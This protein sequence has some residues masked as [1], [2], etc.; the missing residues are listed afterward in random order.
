MSK[1]NNKTDKL[2]KLDMRFDEFIRPRVQENFIEP[3]QEILG[4]LLTKESWEDEETTYYETPAQLEDRVK[5]WVIYDPEKNKPVYT[6]LE[7]LQFKVND[8]AVKSY[9]GFVENVVRFKVFKALLGHNYIEFVKI[10]SKGRATTVP[11]AFIWNLE[12]WP[13]Y[14]KAYGASPFVNYFSTVLDYRSVFQI[15]LY[16]GTFGTGAARALYLQDAIQKQPA[17]FQPSRDFVVVPKPVEE[18]EYSL[19][20]SYGERAMRQYALSSFPLVKNLPHD[21]LTDIKLRSNWVEPMTGYTF[22]GGEIDESDEKQLETAPM[23]DAM[24]PNLHNEIIAIKRAARLANNKDYANLLHN[25]EVD[26]EELF[27]APAFEETPEFQSEE[28]MEEPQRHHFFE[29][30]LVKNIYPN[31]LTAGSYARWNVNQPKLITQ[32]VEAS[33]FEPIF[34]PWASELT[35]LQNRS[36]SDMTLAQSNLG[37]LVTTDTELYDDETSSIFDT[38]EESEIEEMNAEESNTDD[39]ESPL[40][41][42]YKS[43]VSEHIGMDDP[44]NAQFQ[45]DLFGSMLYVTDRQDLPYKLDLDDRAELKTLKRLGGE[46]VELTWSDLELVGALAPLAFIWYIGWTLYS[47]RVHFIY[48][49]R[50]KPAPILYTR[51]DHFGRLPY[52]VQFHEIVGLEAS[53][54]TIEKLFAGLQRARGMSVYMPTVILSAWE[55]AISPFIPVKVDNWL[56]AQRNKLKRLISNSDN[57]SPNFANREINLRE[58]LLLGDL[59]DRKFQPRFKLLESVIDYQTMKLTE[60]EKNGVVDL[61]HLQEKLKS[62][63]VKLQEKVPRTGKFATVGAKL[64]TYVGKVFDIQQLVKFSFKTLHFV[65]HELSNAPIVTAFKPGV[66]DLN[67]LPKGM[68]LVGEPGNG[69]SFFARAI[70]SET[71]LPFFKTESN[72]FIDPKFGVLRLM[73]LFRRVRNQAPGV[74]FIRDIDLITV[75]RERTNSPELIQL[76]T[77]FLICFDGYYVGSE[78]RPTQRKIFTLGSVSDLTKMDP[79]CLRS[80]RF[81]WIVNL[82]NPVV[83]ERTFLL[84]SKA[85][86]SGIQLD[87]NIAWNYFG[88]ITEGFTNAEVVSVVNTSSLK[89]IKNNTFVHTNTS[90]NDALGGIFALRGNKTSDPSADAGFFNKLHSTQLLKSDASNFAVLETFGIVPF[91]TKCVHLLSSL[92]DWSKT[93]KSNEG[94]AVLTMQNIG[95]NIQHSTPLYSDRLMSEVLDFLAEGAFLK[96]LRRC[97]SPNTFVTQTTYC[98]NLVKHLNI[99]FGE[100]CDRY[101]LD[102]T[103]RPFQQLRVAVKSLKA[104]SNWETS[105]SLYLIDLHERANLLSQWYASRMFCEVKPYKVTGKTQTS[106]SMDYFKE[107]INGRLREFTLHP[108]PS[109]SE[110][111]SLRNTFTTRGFRTRLQRPMAAPIKQMSRELLEMK[112]D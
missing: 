8:I 45:T 82:R 11:E 83:G 16:V 81:E 94:P 46:P 24:I 63:E 95:M 9:Q 20:V 47:F 109:H 105:T 26:N 49:V 61:Y 93:E 56:M 58:E 75:D 14:F 4:I 76:T 19:V 27:I 78:A 17:R 42:L 53:E 66:Y 28:T 72:R 102:R 64:T 71:R 35:P 97:G 77:Q 112:L 21:E 96:Q 59:D 104:S 108:D 50:K 80:G 33:T 29:P 7:L 36:S 43:M 25:K 38:S 68:L 84:Q 23:Y 18:Q 32:A 13:K 99:T 1:D 41:P 87:S 73:A 107:R 31:S 69:R 101:R 88:A 39:S 2:P 37:R 92:K 86:K 3:N 70:A 60:F 57:Q 65:E 34:N 90:L 110:N 100:G 89:A 12:Y 85:S 67:D 79:A 74:L 98:N 10:T 40:E 44:E 54:H 30:D 55:S 103:S 91:R 51:F 52:K 111:Q 15:L 62:I 5:N 22:I 48:N 106:A 6:R